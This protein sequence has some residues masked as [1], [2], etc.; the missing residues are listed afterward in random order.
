VYCGGRHF[1]HCLHL[2]LQ[3]ARLAGA[4]PQS[5]PSPPPPGIACAGQPIIEDLACIAAKVISLTTY[6]FNSLGAPVG[7]QMRIFYAHLPSLPC[8]ALPPHLHC[9]SVEVITLNALTHPPTHLRTPRPSKHP[10]TPLQT[11]PPHHPSTKPSPLTHLP[12]HPPT[13]LPTC[14]SNY[15]RT[16]SSSS[17]SCS[18]ASYSGT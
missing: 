1:A 11:D 17:I 13:H 15:P 3:L 2:R 8:R 18:S 4:C 6:D 16:S 9:M 14:R 5:I 7:A 12:T 10:L